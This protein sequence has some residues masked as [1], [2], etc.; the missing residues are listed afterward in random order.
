MKD[1]FKLIEKK[2]ITLPDD[3]YIL[4]SSCKKYTIYNSVDQLADAALGGTGNLSYE[5]KYE[6][7]GKGEYTEAV[8]HKVTNGISANYTDAYMRRRDPD[9]MAIADNLPSDKTRFK[10]KFGYEFESLKTET[11]N[12]LKEQELAV[13]FYFAGNTFSTR[14]RTGWVRPPWS[15]TPPTYVSIPGRR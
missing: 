11:F 10:D 7:P 15:S 8:I 9:T 12:W 14:S 6:I 2:K 1:F 13:F 3:V 5:V 4:L